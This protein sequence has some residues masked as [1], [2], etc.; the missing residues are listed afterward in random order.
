MSEGNVAIVVPGEDGG[1]T[2]FA[3]IHSLVDAPSGFTFAKEGSY[4]RVVPLRHCTICRPPHGV[5]PVPLTLISDRTLYLLHW[6]LAMPRACW[7][8]W[9]CFVVVVVV[10][11][12]FFGVVLW[13]PK[14]HLCLV[15]FLVCGY[16]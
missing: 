9:C 8:C 5:T 7:C 11:V 3:T 16:Q 1:L 6:Y 12:T 4:Q 15:C 13:F 10:V 2:Q 14:F